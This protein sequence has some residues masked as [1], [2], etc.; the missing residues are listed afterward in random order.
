MFLQETHSNTLNEEEWR[1]EWE[2]D[3]I[4]SH[5]SPVSGGV[6]I[7]FAKGFTPLRVEVEEEVQGR[8]LNMCAA[9]E[10]VM[11]HLA[12]VYAS[13]VGSEKVGFFYYLKN[14][15]IQY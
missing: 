4:N 3:V 10:N 11:I 15:I 2:G 5:K 6:A 1:C 9:F 13:I 7:L 12:N 14:T 8:P